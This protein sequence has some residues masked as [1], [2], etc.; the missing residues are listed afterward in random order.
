MREMAKGKFVMFLACGVIP[1][2]KLTDFQTDCHFVHRMNLKLAALL[3]TEIVWHK[4]CNI[5][6]T[7][8]I[9]LGITYDL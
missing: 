5:S 6:Y 8:S 7:Q 4:V 1:F 2:L 9:D 3:S